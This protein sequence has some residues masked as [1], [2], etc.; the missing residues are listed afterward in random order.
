VTIVF[1]ISGHGFGHAVRM[2]EVMRA[3]HSMRPGWRLLA[4]TQAPRSMLPEFIEYE[5]IE[6]DSGVVEREAGVI[7]DE[8]ATTH[9]LRSF[10]ERWDE[11]VAAETAFVRDQRVRLIVADIPPI[12]GDIAHASGVPCVAITNF[13]W[14]W[15]HEPYARAYLGPLEA[16]YSRIGTLLRLPFA[17]SSR[18][19]GFRSI[20][21]VPLIARTSTAAPVPHSKRR[22][23]LGSRAQVSAEA[24]A[25]ASASAPQFEFV[26]PAPHDNFPD[27]LASCDVVIA[28]LGFS[29]VAEC[30][31]ARK[32]LLYPPRQGFREESLLQHNLARHIP[33]LAIPLPDFYGG[34]W[35]PYLQELSALPAVT[36]SLRT[37]GA[38]VCAGFLASFGF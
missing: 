28:K 25:L 13:T 32:P 29:M 5:S 37:D 31:A 9:R 16:A 2:G 34:H 1:Y 8:A 6:I 4:R 18:L 26:V 30:I 20:I 14:D 19:E 23:L 24:L 7:V 21:D 27:V 22:A 35:A 33:A 36:S 11:I 15:I 10:L 17:Q 12:A 38:A 3:L